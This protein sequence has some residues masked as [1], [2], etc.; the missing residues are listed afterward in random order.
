[1]FQN[2]KALGA[3][4]GLMQNKDKIKAAVERFRE[5]IER[6]SVTG[7][8]GGGAVRATVS[9]KLRITDINLDPALI[10]GLQSGESGRTMAQ[11]LIVEAVNDG[12]SKAQA[13]LQEEADKQ[14]K[15]LGLPGLPGLDS[16]TA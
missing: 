15:E 3:L 8:A 7:T 9:G 16:L 6:I 14:A 4:A 12:L 2:F 5:K 13:L 10:A 11:S 1:M